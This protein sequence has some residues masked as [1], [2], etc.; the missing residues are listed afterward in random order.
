MSAA[1]RERIGV[2]AMIRAGG[3]TAS[4]YTGTVLGVFVV[5]ALLAGAAGFGIA[6]VLGSEFAKR[7]RFDEAVSGDLTA[8]VE[9][10]KHAPA[11]F[12]ASFWIGVAAVLLWV[13]A[14]WFLVGGVYAVA[15]ER[16]EGKRE[17][18]R[19]FGAGGASTFLVYVRLAV[20]ASVLHLVVMVA[21]VLGLGA[22]A[23]RM[24][25]ALTLPGLLIPLLVGLLP[26]IVIGVY[27]WTAI[28]YARAELTVRRPTHDEL[29]AFRALVRALVFV[30]RRPVA[31]GHAALG[32]LVF[33]VVTLGY[34][35]AAQ[36]HAMLG[37]GGAI[38]LLVIRLGL[39][40]VRFGVKFTVLAGQIELTETR[41][42]PARRVVEQES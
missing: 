24:T 22:A 9:C 18:A 42:P 27:V 41:P 6:Q 10:I 1:R 5:Q 14:S 21:L 30:A 13:V 16:P 32:W 36:G 39:S 11:A 28:D 20:L 26:A 37:T 40:L 33:V 2:G 12:K 23:E 7:P 17:T 25:H 38:A 19:C 15:H 29:G 35:W 8:L 31:L 3:R 4:H 34:V